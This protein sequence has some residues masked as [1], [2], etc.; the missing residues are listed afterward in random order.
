MLASDL[1]LRISSETAP[2]GG[3]AQIKVLAATPQH[4][5]AGR[6]V[7]TFDPAVFGDI[8]GVAVFSAE[9]DAMGIATISG[10]SL[11]VSFQ[12]TAG[13]IGQLPQLPILTVTIPVLA[14]ATVGTAS[15]V[16]I[17][18]SQGSWRDAQNNGYAVTAAPGLVTVGGS[19]SVRSLVP[20]GGLLPAGALVHINGTGFSPA[21][22]VRI[23]A[24]RAP[25]LWRRAK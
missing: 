15:V 1:A 7:M 12:S 21:T 23:D 8:T 10:Q 13:G 25:N 4:I 20:G 16:T 11:D 3:W 22:T 9:G 2:A 19:L 18:A 6:I 14:T 24:W 17:D 5:A